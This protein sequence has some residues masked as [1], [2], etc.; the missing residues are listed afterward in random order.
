M[1]RLL[2]LSLFYHLTYSHPHP[3]VHLKGSSCLDAEFQSYHIHTLFWHNNKNSTAAAEDLLQGFMTRFNLD[4]SNMCQYNPGDLRETDLCVFE[5]DYEA[6]GP[7]LTGQTAVFVP[8]SMYEETV[9]WM[10]KHKGFLDVF[11]HPNSGCG[12]EDHLMHG[13]WAGNKWELD[14]TIFLD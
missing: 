1:L 6:A 8:V 2:L 9:S 4:Q 10:V 7:F 3:G 5:T 14:G 12:I 13:L 11:V